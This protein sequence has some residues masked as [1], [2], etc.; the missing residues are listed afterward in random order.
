[1]PACKRVEN[2]VISGNSRRDAYLARGARRAVILPQHHSLLMSVL[3]TLLL[4][5]MSD[6]MAS[7]TLGDES[8]AGFRSHNPQDV[9]GLPSF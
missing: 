6:K 5:Q 7:C 9:A 4:Y 2:D 1:M 3:I 8:A